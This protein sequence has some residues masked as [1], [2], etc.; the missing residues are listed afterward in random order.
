VLEG[1][2]AI[3]TGGAS[4]MGA[5]T[6][7]RFAHEGASVVIAD[8]DVPRAEGLA[9][10]LAPRV[11]FERCNV[12]DESDVQR[13]VEGT[14]RLYGRLDCMFNNAGIGGAMTP[15]DELSLDEWHRFHDVCLTGVF[16]GMK[17][18]ARV[19]KR[20][21]SGSII[22]TASVAGLAA[23]YGPHPYSSAKAAVIHLTKAVAMEMAK[24][25]VRVNCI[26]PGGIVTSIFARSAG[27]SGDQADQLMAPIAQAMMNAQPI[28]RAGMPQDIA[29]AAL[30]LASDDS[31]FVTGQTLVVDGGHITGQSWDQL[32]AT[33]NSFRSAMG[34]SV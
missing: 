23:C 14:A 20:Q 13:V 34:I 24:Y 4:G 18:A 21:R 30:W 33:W 10:E 2:V 6:V 26:A 9:A 5:G 19:M 11:T 7:R 1:K 22:S 8:V 27:L 25:T 16:L 31:S 29:G 32:V 3:V 17:H 28:P 15:I 12:A